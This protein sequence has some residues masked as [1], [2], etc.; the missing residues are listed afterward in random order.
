MTERRQGD[1]RETT[2]DEGEVNRAKKKA[3]ETSTSLGPLVSFFFF[4]SSFFFF[5]L[6]IIFGTNVNYGK[7]RRATTRKAT[8]HP[9][10]TPTAA[11]HCSQSGQRVLQRQ[12]RPN[13]G[14][15]GT[16]TTTTTTTTTNITAPRATAT[17]NC[18]G[19]GNGGMTTTTGQR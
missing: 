12:G 6:T 18:S 8:Q 2:R 9:A 17:S 16:Q 7:D 10:P 4:F 14:T 19:G 3:Q 1:D 13:D 15:T 11:S 5:S